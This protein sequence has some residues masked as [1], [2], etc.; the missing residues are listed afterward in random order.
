MLFSDFI[1]GLKT[2]FSEISNNRIT[3]LNDSVK[4]YDAADLTQRIDNK[5][6]PHFAAISAHELYNG[7]VRSH[8]MQLATPKDYYKQY[9]DSI[10]GREI[11]LDSFSSQLEKAPKA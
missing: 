5:P 9:T 2:H 11:V 7:F 6:E 8:A 4:A 10:K 3:P 1:S